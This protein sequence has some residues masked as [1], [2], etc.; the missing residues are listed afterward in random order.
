MTPPDVSDAA[1]EAAIAE[2]IEAS[3]WMSEY[4][5]KD[6]GVDRVIRLRAALANVTRLRTQ[7]NAE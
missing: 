1:V 4:F 5:H 7:E 3:E 2:L 6:S